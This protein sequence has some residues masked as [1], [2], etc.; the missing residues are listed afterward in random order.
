[1]ILPI[2]NKYKWY[3]NYKIASAM[4]VNSCTQSD[5]LLAKVTKTNINLYQQLSNEIK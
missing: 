2:T 3:N 1:M 4:F 5:E